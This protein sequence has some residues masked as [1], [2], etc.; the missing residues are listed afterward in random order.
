M[1]KAEKSIQDTLTAAKMARNNPNVKLINRD[2]IEKIKECRAMVNKILNQYNMVLMPT[3]TLTPM[4]VAKAG[5][6]FIP[7][8]QI[9]PEG[10]DNAT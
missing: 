5:V 4:G 9:K 2:D 3:I 10:E 8:D 1:D 7:R 6:N